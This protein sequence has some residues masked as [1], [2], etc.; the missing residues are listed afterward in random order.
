VS[1]DSLFA[2]NALPSSTAGSRSIGW[3]G[4]LML[5]F[6]EIAVF[7]SLIVTYFYFYSGAPVWPIGGISPPSL[8]LPTINALILFTSVIPII[9]A[10]KAIQ[11]GDVKGLK[12]GYAIAS[13]MALVFLVLKFVEYSGYDYFW[14]TNAY[15]S[16]VWTITG[17]HSAH[18]LIVLLKAIVIQILAWKGFFYERRYAAVQG[19][20]LY[21]CFVAAVWVPLFATLYIFPNV[22]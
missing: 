9:M 1:A 19:N 10:E 8:P 16:I 20:T 18:V 15:G 7:S 2:A 12:I 6:I 21:W 11:R 5:V 3:W 22:I 14:D 4:I 17:F 13:V